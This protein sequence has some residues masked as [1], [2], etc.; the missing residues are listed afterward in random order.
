M[1]KIPVE[2]EVCTAEYFENFPEKLITH[3]AVKNYEYEYVCLKEDQTFDLWSK[4]GYE[5]QR[6]VIMI[7]K[8]TGEDCYDDETIN[9]KMKS[10]YI[11]ALWTYQEFNINSSGE[12]VVTTAFHYH[13]GDYFSVVQHDMVEFSEN[14]LQMN[15]ESIFK[16]WNPDIIRKFIH[17][18]KPVRRLTGFDG[19]IRLEFAAS[20][21]STLYF[22]KC[23]TIID[24]TVQAAGFF[25]VL[26]IIFYLLIFGV[27]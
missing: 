24:V 4:S 22:R 21:D 27:L 14:H 23:P 20:P 9:N 13:V 12:Q 7:D 15:D 25:V 16:F 6:L 3:Y 1:E 26:L 10:M 5:F 8:C 17:S 18:S 2:Y 11:E 19:V